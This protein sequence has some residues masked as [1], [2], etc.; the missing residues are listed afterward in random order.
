MN[1]SV[2]HTPSSGWMISKSSMTK[3][4]AFIA[5]GLRKDTGLSLSYLT[6]NRIG[7]AQ[8]QI[9]KLSRAQ[10]AGMALSLINKPQHIYTYPPTG[11][12]RQFDPI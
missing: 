9:Q 11:S 2:P 6:T 4:I 10:F 8:S 5:D 7:I 3:Y 1:D 12:Q